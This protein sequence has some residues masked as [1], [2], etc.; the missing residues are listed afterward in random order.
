M[1]ATARSTSLM[2]TSVLAVAAI[3]AS[4]ATLAE[5]TKCERIPLGPEAPPGI[6]GH[7]QIVGKEPI[8]GRPYS[9]ALDVS[10]GRDTYLLVRTIKTKRLLGQAWM[11]TCG[12]DKI[13]VLVLE[14]R[15][16][17]QPI[18]GHCWPRMDGDN[19]W[20]VTCRT[21]VRSSAGLEAWFQE[22]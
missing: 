3:G 8:T 22:Y 9:G 11:E 6:D 15:T 5:T 20:H 21:S 1:S 12:A 10:E 19:Y 14:Y 4:S 7:Y 2:L 13:Q 18:L 17:Q 16:E